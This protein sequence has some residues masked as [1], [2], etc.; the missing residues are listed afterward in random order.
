MPS[1]SKL[2]DCKSC[3]GGRVAPR[4]AASLKVLSGSYLND[5]DGFAGADFSLLVP[6]KRSKEYGAIRHRVADL[7]PQDAWQSD[8][9]HYFVFALKPA[10]D[11]QFSGGAAL[12]LFALETGEGPVSALVINP[13]SD[14]MEV[15]VQDLRNPGT[16]F[17]AQ[18]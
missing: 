11:V 15:G 17:T 9:L 10:A 1:L 18:L 8:G 4:G 12:A 14:E 6:L 13:E 7:K 16:P 2:S 5:D 3:G